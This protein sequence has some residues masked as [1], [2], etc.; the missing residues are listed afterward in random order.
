LHR[1]AELDIQISILQNLRFKGP[2]SITNVMRQANTN[3]INLDS[4]LQPLEAAG[5]IEKTGRFWQITERGI[6]CLDL[7][8]RAITMI[9]PIKDPFPQRGFPRITTEAQKE[10]EPNEDD[11]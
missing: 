4:Y 7:L 6:E 2:T 10:H 3:Y 9:R 1:R 8:E 11:S 5:L